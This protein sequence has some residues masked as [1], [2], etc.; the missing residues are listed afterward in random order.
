[1]VPFA[2]RDAGGEAPIR[3]GLSPT[4]ATTPHYVPNVFFAAPRPETPG[5]QAH[6]L[7]GED[8]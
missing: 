2:V 7:V 4:L 1:V 3:F 5:E 8:P 6:L